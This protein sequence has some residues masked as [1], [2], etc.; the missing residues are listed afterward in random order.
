MVMAKTKLNLIGWMLFLVTG[1][2][3]SWLPFGEAK[4]MYVYVNDK[5]ISVMTDSVDHIPKKYRKSV[6]VFEM[7]EESELHEP[8]Q[9]VE[10]VSQEEE[11]I[12]EPED[13]SNVF[14]TI[15]SINMN[16]QTLMLVGGGLVILA[17]FVTMMFSRNIAMKFAMK[18]VLMLA[19]V[20]TGYGWYFSSMGL[21]GILENTGQGEDGPKPVLEQVRDE[22]QRAEHMQQQKIQALEKILG[23][24]G[25]PKRKR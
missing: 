25:P 20:G 16:K 11:P 22:T 19:I 3:C 4:S 10:A 18:W 12:F 24:D 14:D 1:S 23:E 13:L 6:H 17:S 5:G 21:G 2:L 9:E 8:V 7:P 15:P